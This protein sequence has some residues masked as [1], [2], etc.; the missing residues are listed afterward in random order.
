MN[1]TKVV[2]ADNN[3]KYAYFINKKPMIQV[4]TMTIRPNCCILSWYCCMAKILLLS[5]I[6]TA[7]TSPSEDFISH[8]KVQVKIYDFDSENEILHTK[9]VK[10]N[11]KETYI[12]KAQHF[13]QI[14][15]KIGSI[16]GKEWTLDLNINTDLIPNN[17]VEIYYKNVRN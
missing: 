4:S 10:R 15:L 11:A 9:R 2:K 5:L 13:Q 7:Y 17:Y 8:E 3:L 12:N 16:S 14:I 1:L 6:S